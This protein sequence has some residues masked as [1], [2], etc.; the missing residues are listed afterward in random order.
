MVTKINKTLGRVPAIIV[1]VQNQSI[2]NSE[3]VFV[4]LSIQHSMRKHH[5]A[6]CGLSGS[7][8]FLSIISQTTRFRK[9]SY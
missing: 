6:I 4:A 7:K 2:A 9:K 1:A 5:I 3:G 8:I